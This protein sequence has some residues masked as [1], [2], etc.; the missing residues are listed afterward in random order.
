MFIELTDHLRCPAAHDESFLVLI[1]DRS[2]GRSV[3]AGLLGCPV[4]HREYRIADGRTDF[5]AP[6][7]DTPGAPDP[8]LAEALAVFLGLAGPGGYVGLIG[9]AGGLA[10]EL[11]QRL[12][13]VHIAAVNPPA[14]SAMGPTVSLLRSPRVPFK[15]RSLRGV[16]LSQPFAADAQWQA[17]AISAVLPGLR[18]V[19]QGAAPPGLEI[20][21]EAGGWWVGKGK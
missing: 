7:V 16:V 13:G 19:G 18:I 21:G 17:E 14:G 9:E 5:G 6:P 4:C 10:S 12:P 8:A 20:L 11:S 3:V 1:P 15:S 2:E